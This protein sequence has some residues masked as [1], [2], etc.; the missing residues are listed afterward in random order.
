MLILLAEDEHDLAELTIDYLH[1]ENIECDYAH[2]GA[3]ALNLACE[4]SYEVIVLDVMM[5][6]LDGFGVCRELKARGITTPVIFLTAKDALDDKLAG[7]ELGAQD[8][9]TKPFDLPELVAR[10][11]VLASRK[12]QA[13]TVFT[14]DTLTIDKSQHRVT[15]GDRELALSP[16]L[17]ILLTTLAQ[18]SPDVVSRITLENAIWP[19]DIPGKDSLKTLVFR[20]RSIIDGTNEL[21]LVQTIRGAGITLRIENHD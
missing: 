4:N 8:Y 3:M 7:F 5:P 21:P 9:L 1:C 18:N 19:D 2:D 6:R 17:W 13:A 20:L 16:S 15:R 12:P 11:K 14:L 10:I